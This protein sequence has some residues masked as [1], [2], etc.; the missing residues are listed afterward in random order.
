MAPAV[1][2]DCFNPEDILD[3]KNDCAVSNLPADNRMR[4]NNF[5]HEICHELG[6][7]FGPDMVFV[8]DADGLLVASI[9]SDQSG[10]GCLTDL[11]ETAEDDD[12]T[13]WE[14]DTMC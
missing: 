4:K 12:I 14:T 7:L 10:V 6:R 8:F 11:N 13:L 2:T 9:A 1:A 3:G 5:W